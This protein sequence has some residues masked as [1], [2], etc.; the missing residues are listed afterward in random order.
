[1][2]QFSD[3]REFLP[4]LCSVLLSCVGPGQA[5][6]S[7]GALSVMKVFSSACEST[8]VWISTLI[9]GDSRSSAAFTV[10]AT[11]TRANIVNHR[12]MLQK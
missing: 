11:H 3:W 10:A 5:V 4:E 2:M 12:F 7:K 9:G 8:E 1:M 6:A